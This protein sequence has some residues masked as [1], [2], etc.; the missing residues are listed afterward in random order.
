MNLEGAKDM[1]RMFYLASA[2]NGGVS[3]WNIGVATNLN[4]VFYGA[5]SFQGTGITSWNVAS[6]LTMSGMFY[7]AQSFNTG[8]ELLMLPLFSS[9][10]HL[11]CWH[12]NS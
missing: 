7:N 1:Y 2:F 9:H 12:F 8:I 3:N 6:A 4:D 10:C 11:I 5:T